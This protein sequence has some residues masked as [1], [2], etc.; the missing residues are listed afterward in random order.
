MN[1]I[2]FYRI[3]RALQ[4]E[5]GIVQNDDSLTMEEK[6]RQIIELEKDAREIMS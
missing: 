4:R 2:K 5:I 1:D 6:D 3:D